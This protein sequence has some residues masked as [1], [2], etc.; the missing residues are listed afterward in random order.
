[1][2]EQAAERAGA[3]L[4]GALARAVTD[5]FD[6]IAY[7]QVFGRAQGGDDGGA[8]GGYQLTGDRCGREGD[9]ACLAQVDD[10]GHR[11]GHKAVGTADGAVALGERLD[12][13][14]LDAQIIET[15]GDRADVD[16]GVDGAYLVKH[17]GVGRGSVRLG[18]RLGELGEHGVGK[19][20]GALGHG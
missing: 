1:M 14:I 7:R 17:H 13:N 11:D 10:G 19:L 3:A 2:N 20:L 5:G 12:H 15:D 16:D 18:L 6:A 8:R 9:I 4:V